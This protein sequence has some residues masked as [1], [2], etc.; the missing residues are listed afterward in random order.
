ME[1]FIDILVLALILGGTIIPSLLKAK[2]KPNQP[3][4]PAEEYQ[5]WEDDTE[6]LTVTEEEF[7]PVTNVN[8]NNEAASTIWSFDQ[9]A[10]D[11]I[12]PRNDRLRK[13]N[14]AIITND[15]IKDVIINNDVSHGVIEN[16][17]LYDAVIYSEILNPKFKD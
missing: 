11:N 4:V 13:Q 7:S 14:R 17:N 6:Y 9:E 2:K 16:F 5:G 1:S 3:E 15:E 8:N 10:I 12:G